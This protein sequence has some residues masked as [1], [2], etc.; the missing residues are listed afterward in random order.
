M[1]ED[2]INLFFNN[3]FDVNDFFDE[4]FF[5]PSPAIA[6]N[7]GTATAAPEIA[8]APISIYDQSV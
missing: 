7:E 3:I 1:N 4:D 6:L 5:S 8:A 2:E